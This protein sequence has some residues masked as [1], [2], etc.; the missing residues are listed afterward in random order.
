MNLPRATS[1]VIVQ[2]QDEA[3]FLLD[4]E[5]GEVFR[6]NETA[7]RIFELCQGDTSLEGAVATLALRLGAAGQE[8]A[9]RADVQRTVTQFQEL[10]LCE[11]S[12]PV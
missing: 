8:E 1:G 4:T 11:P 9:I 10:G 7:A 2:Q 5:G 3:F 6:V 12:R